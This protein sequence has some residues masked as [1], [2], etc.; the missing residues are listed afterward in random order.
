MSTISKHDENY[1]IMNNNQA[2]LNLL[3]IARRAGELSSGEETVL[4]AIRNQD[5]K[6]VFIAQDTG[7]SSSKKNFKINVSSITLNMI[8]HLTN[9]NLI[10][11]QVKKELFMQ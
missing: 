11:Q 2:I 9:S 10:R 1:L 3:G 7:E 5:A 8:K 6:F 4:K